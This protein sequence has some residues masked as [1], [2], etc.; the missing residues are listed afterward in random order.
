VTVVIG[1]GCVGLSSA[2]LLLTLFPD[3]RVLVI[4]RCP[5]RLEAL[6]VGRW[7]VDADLAAQLTRAVDRQQLH[8]ASHL[9]ARPHRVLVCVPTPAAESGTLDMTQVFAAVEPLMKA[10]DAP[11]GCALWL[12]STL[13]PGTARR[14]AERLPSGWPVGVWP[15]FLRAEHAWADTLRPSRLLLGSDDPHVDPPLIDAL[16]RVFPDTPTVRTSLVTAELSK[17]AANAALSVHYSL[18]NDFAAL[19]AQTGADAGQLAEVLSADVRLG[20]GWAVTPGWGGAC[21][22]KDS[23][24]LVVFAE[25]SGAPLPVV[26]AA[27]RS[28]A[29]RTALAL[30]R[31]RQ[32]RPVRGARVLLTGLHGGPHPSAG[33]SL[34]TALNAEGANVQVRSDGDRSE[35]AWAETDVLVLLRPWAQ[36]SCALHDQLRA[37]PADRPLALLTWW[38]VPALPGVCCLR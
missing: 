21:L 38:P 20:Q 5:E 9:P 36:L 22:P 33:A 26:D 3:E 1:G 25:R 12:R 18:M 16:T 27:R 15:E 14:V 6:Q 11:T 4:E 8:F 19:A 28:N 13:M 32:C 10:Q 30:R 29:A 2:G 17:L 34:L 24:A 7:A 37:R 31:I 35:I 23:R